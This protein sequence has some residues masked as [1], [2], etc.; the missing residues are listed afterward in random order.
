LADPADRR[1]SRA[2]SDVALTGSC[3]CGG[4]RFE[5]APPLGRA[6]YCHC[7]R[8][9]RRTGGGGSAQVRVASGAVRVVEGEALVGSWR[10]TDGFA[11]EFCSRCGA[12]LWSRDPASGDVFSVRMGAFD[13]DP[14][15]RPSF[16]QFVDDA[17][18]WE[19]VPDD[20]LERFGGSAWSSAALETM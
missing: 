18:P 13:T 7:T 17:A 15:V 8:C 9:Q 14:G 4:V 5:V 16:R 6:G 1:Y 10:P 2:V 19:P 12:Q 20:G 3:L 11:K